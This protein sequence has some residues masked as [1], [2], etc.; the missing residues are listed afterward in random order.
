MRPAFIG[1]RPLFMHVCT[2][3]SRSS[4]LQVFF[5][6]AHSSKLESDIVALSLGQN[7]DQCS[8]ENR[9]CTNLSSC[10][11]YT[12]LTIIEWA[13]PGVNWRP[14]LY[15]LKDVINPWPLNGTGFYSEEASIRGNIVRTFPDVYSRL[16]VV[17][18]VCTC[19]CPSFDKCIQQRAMNTL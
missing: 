5:C 18:K 14:G 6:A 12:R 7:G 17:S 1:N 10:C 2:C 3:S 9:T 16:Q 13:G 15:F 19:A 11:I 4:F 8:Y